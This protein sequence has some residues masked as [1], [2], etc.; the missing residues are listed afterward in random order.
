LLVPG[1]SIKRARIPNTS[2]PS[3]IC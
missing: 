1:P 3:K 2:R